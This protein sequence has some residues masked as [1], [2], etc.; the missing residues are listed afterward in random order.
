MI[1]EWSGISTARRASLQ[2]AE[3]FLAA[4]G[5]SPNDY[6]YVMTASPMASARYVVTCGIDDSEGLNAVFAMGDLR[7]RLSGETALTVL[8]VMAADDDLRRQISGLAAGA[9]LVDALRAFGL[10]PGE[11]VKPKVGRW[12]IGLW[13]AHDRDGFAVF[14]VDWRGEVTVIGRASAAGAAF[15]FAATQ[16]DRAGNIRQQARDYAG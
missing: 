6:A 11:I 15:L 9:D 16:R 3:R 8:C 14:D 1:E 5:L 10:E 7:I 12:D 13:V 2:Q 4:H